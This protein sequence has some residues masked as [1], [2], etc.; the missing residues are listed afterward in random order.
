[1]KFLGKI[2]YWITYFTASLYFKFVH[3]WKIKGKENRKQDGPLIIMAN[4]TSVLD[5]PIVG[6]IMNR[7]VHFM[8]K[9]EL[10][11]NPIFRRF[12]KGIGTF[13]VRRGKPDRKALK[14]AFKLLNND[15]VICI[16]PEGTRHSPDNL[17][18]AKAGAVMIALKSQAPILPVGIIN[19]KNKKKLKISIGEPFTLDQYYDRKVKRDERKEVGNIIMDRIEKEIKSLK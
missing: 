14:N 19:T 12:L 13:P 16:F 11:K 18:K 6:C 4:H 9:E 1:M 8:A 7:Q 2:L 15:K 17:G 5:P 10:F 3:R